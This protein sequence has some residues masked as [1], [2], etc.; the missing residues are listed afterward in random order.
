MFLRVVMREASWA[1]RNIST[2]PSEDY[3]EC[4]EVAGCGGESDGICLGD[5]SG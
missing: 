2:N 1:L 4:V 3:V 5:T